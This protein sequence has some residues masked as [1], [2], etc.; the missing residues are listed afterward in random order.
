[1][2][3]AISQVKNLKK[4]HYNKKLKITKIRT[5][6]F[7][8]LWRILSQAGGLLLMQGREGGGLAVNA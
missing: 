3:S 2:V 1:M 7:S 8:F 6:N 5:Q 4:I